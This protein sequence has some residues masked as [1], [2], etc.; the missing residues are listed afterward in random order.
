MRVSPLLRSNLYVVGFRASAL[1]GS[2]C[3]SLNRRSTT[4]ERGPFFPWVENPRLE[5]RRDHF[6]SAA[7]WRRFSSAREIEYSQRAGTE[8]RRRFRGRVDVT[9]V[10]KGSS[11][12]LPAVTL[13]SKRRQVAALQVAFLVARGFRGKNHNIL[14]LP[15]RRGYPH[16]ANSATFD[17]V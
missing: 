10:E 6:W 7:T 2:F 16:L 12:G 11:H 13:S 3:L 17:S 1:F 5:C 15:E 8:N 4:E 9:G 14:G